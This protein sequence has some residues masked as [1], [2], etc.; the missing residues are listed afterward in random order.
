M[1][2]KTLIYRMQ[3]RRIFRSKRIRL[4]GRS[5]LLVLF[6]IGIGTILG[7]AYAAFDYYEAL[8]DDPSFAPV[9]SDWGRR[10]DLTLEG[11]LNGFI[12]GCLACF[13]HFVLTHPPTHRR[14]AEPQ[15]DYDTSIW[16][17]PPTAPTNE[18]T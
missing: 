7:F 5:V 15:P 2:R 9:S 12:M 1:K 16:P 4:F 18:Q 3:L 13:V 10:I 8:R 17:P 6:C 14:V 11:A